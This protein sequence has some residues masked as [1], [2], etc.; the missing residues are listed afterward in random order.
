MMSLKSLILSSM[1][2]TSLLK[3]LEQGSFFLL[4]FADV[5]RISTFSTRFSLPAIYRTHVWKV[6]LGKQVNF[7]GLGSRSFISYS[8]TGK[9]VS[10]RNISWMLLSCKRK[11]NQAWEN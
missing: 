6:I 8:Q 2:Q 7:T 5:K 11:D 1:F 9:T 4:I 3:R 10:I